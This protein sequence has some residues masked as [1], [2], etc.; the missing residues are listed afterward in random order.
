ELLKGCYIADIPVAL[1]SID[2]CF[3][4]EDRLVFVDVE[5]EHSWVWSMEELRKYSREFNEKERRW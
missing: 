1:A 5:K 3:S 4:C 2:P